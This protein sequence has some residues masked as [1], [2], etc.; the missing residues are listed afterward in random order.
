MRYAKC[1]LA[2]L[3]LAAVL[4]AADPIVGNWKLNPAKSK[5]KAGQPPKE[6]TV[7][8][9]EAG[10]DFD[11]TIK[12]TS[13]QGTPIST[14]YTVPAAGGQGKIIESPYDAVSRK[15][16][17]Q[18]QA[19]ITSSKGGKVVMTV[20]TRVSADG[21]TLTANV[22]GVDPTGSPVDGTAVLEKQ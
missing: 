17:G 16:L 3:G 20:R 2:L 1:V 10:S 7:T 21:K 5:Y 9:V 19:E 4:S 13:A 22:K 12:G 8:I 6:E 18:R 15:R 11:V 14:H